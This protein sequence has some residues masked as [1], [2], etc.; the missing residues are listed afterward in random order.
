[1]VLIISD[2]HIGKLTDTYNFKECKKKTKNLTSNVKKLMKIVEGS[3]QLDNLHLF[4]LGDILDGEC[5]YKGHSFEIE[6]DS[7]EALKKGKGVFTDFIDSVRWDFDKVKCWCVKGNH[8]VVNR[9]GSTNTNIDNFFYNSLDDIYKKDDGVEFNISDSWY[10]IAKIQKWNYLLTHGNSINMYQNIPLYGCMRKGMNW[11]T[12]GIK[13]D[14]NVLTLGHF[15]TTFQMEFNDLQILGNGTFVTDDPFSQ[16]K[17]GLKG[18]NKFW[19]FG[20]GKDSPIT[21]QYFV[22]L[23]K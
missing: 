15:H 4:F 6:F 19:M 12:G 22:N 20:V 10:Q 17:L 21:W 16:E 14:F 2:V 3:Y 18:S 5:I 7:D 23:N 9:F 8:G 11:K 1:M 13:E